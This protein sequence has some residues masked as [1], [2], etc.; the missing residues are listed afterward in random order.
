MTRATMP[1]FAGLLLLLAGCS[2][3]R[4]DP[5]PQPNDNRGYP[6]DDRG[7]RNDGTYSPARRALQMKGELRLNDRQI[8]QLVVIERDYSR[9]RNRGYGNRGDERRE[10]DRVLNRRQ[11]DILYRSWR[12]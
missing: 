5:Y 9:D 1:A 12:G 7:Y 11:R 8:R 2:Q 10:V 6:Q 4:Y 3:N